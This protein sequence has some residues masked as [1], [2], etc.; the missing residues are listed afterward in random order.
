MKTGHFLFSEEQP[1][2]SDCTGTRGVLDQFVPISHIWL[3]RKYWEWHRV[4]RH[5]LV[6]PGCVIRTSS[7]CGILI[8]CTEAP[9]INC[10]NECGVW[11]KCCG[12]AHCLTLWHRLQCRLQ[13]NVSDI[14]ER[15]TAWHQRRS[16]RTEKKHLHKLL[17]SGPLTLFQQLSTFSSAIILSQSFTDKTFSVRA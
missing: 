12:N 14:P 8:W 6:L 5:T 15:C 4:R 16:N 17:Y 10:E 1:W 7:H 9:S 13:P 2:L 11:R 3:P